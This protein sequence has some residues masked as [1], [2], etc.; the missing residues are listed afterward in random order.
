[1]SNKYITKRYDYYRMN[2]ASES[3]IIWSG[4]PGFVIKYKMIKINMLD[5]FYA[6]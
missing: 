1:M 2:Q 4:A 5:I 6:E 3:E